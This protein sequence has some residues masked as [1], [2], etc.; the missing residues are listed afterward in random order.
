VC[1]NLHI[2]KLSI[3]CQNTRTCTPLFHSNQQTHC[4]SNYTRPPCKDLIH[5]SNVFS[6]CTTKPSNKLFIPFIGRIFHFFF[7][8]CSLCEQ[9]FWRSQKAC[10]AELGSALVLY[11]YFFFDQTFCS[12]EQKRLKTK[13]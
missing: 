13:S 12:F 5:H 8:A 9:R 3:S 7:L 2:I 4:S 1:C 10:P 11:F 6:V